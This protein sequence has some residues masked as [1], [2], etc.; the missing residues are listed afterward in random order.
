ML[1]FV[2]DVGR[3]NAVDAIAGQMWL[4]DTPGHNKLF[5][6]TG[7][8]TSEMVIKVAQMGIPVLLSRSGVT[9]MG[10]TLAQKIGVILIAR[11]RGKHF[12]VYNGA[13]QIEFD[14]IPDKRPAAA[15][16]TEHRRP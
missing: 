15:A 8:L 13:E 14:A 10:Q 16:V 7:R 6:T 2:E 5:Y 12:L 4:N 9:E 3:H 11:A 1:H